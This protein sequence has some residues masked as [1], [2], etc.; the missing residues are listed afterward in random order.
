M[1][2]IAKRRLALHQLRPDAEN[3]DTAIRTATGSPRWTWTGAINECN[4]TH[5]SRFQPLPDA[6]WLACMAGFIERYIALLA[7]LER[8][9]FA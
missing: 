4:R 5:A 9:N 3:G 8:K 7:G 6:P 2:L 1:G